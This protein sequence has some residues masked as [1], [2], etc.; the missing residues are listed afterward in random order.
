[1]GFSG[2]YPGVLCVFDLQS[3]YRT[4]SVTEQVRWLRG[5]YEDAMAS[6]TAPRFFH[7]LAVQ[8]TEF[9]RWFDLQSAYQTAFADFLCFIIRNRRYSLDFILASPVGNTTSYV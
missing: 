1:M 6:G 9:V 5:R 3:A 4:S 8:L 2:T 7:E